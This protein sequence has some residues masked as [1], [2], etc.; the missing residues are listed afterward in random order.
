ML[1]KA[2][3]EGVKAA[4][5]KYGMFSQAFWNLSPEEQKRRVEQGFM[6]QHLSNASRPSIPAL[7]PTPSPMGGSRPPASGA[8]GAGMPVLA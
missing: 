6:L 5:R 8:G 7:R 3:D 4:Y 2:F 1:K